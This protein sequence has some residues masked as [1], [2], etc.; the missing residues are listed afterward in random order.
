MRKILLL[1][2]LSIFVVGCTINDEQLNNDP[3]PTPSAE[4]TPLQLDEMAL[5]LVERLESADITVENIHTHDEE[6]FFDR[7]FGD[8]RTCL[9]Q[10]LFKA[11]CST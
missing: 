7:L 11:T 2:I 10:H 9:Y 8:E 4:V 3:T 1:L 6:S 5:A